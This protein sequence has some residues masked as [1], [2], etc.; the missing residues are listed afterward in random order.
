MFQAYIP[1]WMRLDVV[2]YT[3]HQLSWPVRRIRFKRFLLWSCCWWTRRPWKRHTLNTYLV[4]R[5]SKSKPNYTLSLGSVQ[6]SVSRQNQSPWRYRV[7]LR[8]SQPPEVLCVETWLV[9]TVL[10]AHYQSVQLSWALACPQAGRSRAR[11]ARSCQRCW[12]RSWARYPPLHRH[13]MPL[14]RPAIRLLDPRRAD[15][16]W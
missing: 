13:S 10:W 7:T 12:G 14:T 15:H 1:V 6:A 8:K 2:G 3:V 9:R 4:C 11:M 16:W 5:C